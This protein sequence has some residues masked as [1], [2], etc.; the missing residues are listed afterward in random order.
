MTPALVPTVNK[1]QI[2]CRTHA[3]HPAVW[4]RIPTRAPIVTSQISLTVMSTS[5]LADRFQVIQTSQTKNAQADRLMSMSFEEVGQ[6]TICFGENK[7][8]QKYQDVVKEDQKYCQWFIRRFAE[9]SKPEHQEFLHFLNMYVERRELELDIP[10]APTSTAKAK[11]MP[12]AKSGMAHGSLSE[13]PRTI[14]L[15]LEAESWDQISAQDM[16]TENRNAQRL[17]VIMGQLQL[18]TQAA[19]NPSPA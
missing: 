7:L 15:D 12:K 13:I 17:D 16:M 4:L 10:P 8:G 5:S 14:D 19:Q 2:M 9:S 6:L 11:V 1:D 18:L 3:Y